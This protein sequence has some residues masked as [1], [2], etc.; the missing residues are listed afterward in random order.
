[1]QAHATRQG[2]V[3]DGAGVVEARPAGARETDRGAA[4]SASSRM[5]ASTRTSPPPLSTQAWVPLMSTSVTAG[6]SSRSERAGSMP[7]WRARSISSVPAASRA[8]HPGR[9]ASAVARAG[10]A[11]RAS[12]VK[13][14]GMGRLQM[15]RVT[16]IEGARARARRREG[17]ERSSQGT[18]VPARVRGGAQNWPGCARIQPRATPPTP[19]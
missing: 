17:C 14:L 6:S 3:G 2:A 19:C 11:P 5:P 18:Q 10:G 4:A 15:R 9:D 1:M 13:A 8:P 16:V 7:F 12:N